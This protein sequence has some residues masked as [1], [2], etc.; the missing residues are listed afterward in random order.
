LVFISI[1]CLAGGLDFI[2]M[3]GLA[4]TRE[5][6]RMGRGKGYYDRYL[7]QV[8]EV[9]GRKPATVAVAFKEQIYESIPFDEHDVPVDLVLFDGQ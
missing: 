1:A 5:G 3:P 4:F 8:A 2:L 7:N 9:Q 6:L